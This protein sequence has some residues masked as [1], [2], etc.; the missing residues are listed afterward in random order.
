MY[1]CACVCVC[2]CAHVKECPVMC[3][4]ACV[5][6]LATPSPCL[7]TIDTLPELEVVLVSGLETL[8]LGDLPHVELDCK[9][10][11]EEGRV[12]VRVAIAG[13]GKGLGKRGEVSAFIS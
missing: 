3:V 11:G 8:N 6:I 13:R 9:E 5:N 12:G 2:V 7:V 1:V 4:H 10:H